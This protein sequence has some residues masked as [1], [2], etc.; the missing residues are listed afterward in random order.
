MGASIL[1]ASGA[2]LR[3]D[4]RDC[5]ADSAGI[6][7]QLA[8]LTNDRAERRRDIYAHFSPY[9]DCESPVGRNRS[10]V[11]R[12]ALVG[13]VVNEARGSR[14]ARAEPDNVCR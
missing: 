14:R 6:L 4:R 10:N 13:D 2:P 5:R 1:A 9:V 7:V 11:L 12:D 3:G 8:K